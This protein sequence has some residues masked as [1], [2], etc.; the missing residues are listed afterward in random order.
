MGISLYTGF[1]VKMSWIRIDPLTIRTVANAWLHYVIGAATYEIG[2]F[3][4]FH[5]L[6]HHP[7]F[8]FLHKKH[9]TTTKN[10]NAFGAVYFDPIDLLLSFAHGA[11]C[12]FIFG[13]QNVHI[14]TLLMT[15]IGGNNV[16]SCNPYSLVL[17]NPVL[18]SLIK[19]NIH[20]QLHHALGHEYWHNF[21]AHHLYPNGLQKDVDKY[22]SVMKSAVSFEALPEMSTIATCF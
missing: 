16:H 10:C 3:N 22:N 5:R 17:F 1:L 19:P 14:V 13:M 2:A 15:S 6:M 18:D 12:I 21:P 11:C 8:Y 20:H 7:K 4:L 9:H